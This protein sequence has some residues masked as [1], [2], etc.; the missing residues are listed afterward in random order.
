MGQGSGAYRNCGFTWE[1]GGFACFLILA[2]IINLA[3]NKFKIRN[4]SLMILILSLITTFSTTG[5][6][7]F[8]F[9][10]IWYLFNTEL[11]LTVTVS[12]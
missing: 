8:A 5:Y 2:I 4:K 10:M 12:S 3:S 1:P 11:I 6:M 9:I 7:A